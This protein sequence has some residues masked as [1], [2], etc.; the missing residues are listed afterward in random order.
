MSQDKANKTRVSFKDLQNQ[1]EDL[2]NKRDVLNKKTKEYINSLQEIDKDINNSLKIAKDNYKK[3]RNYWNGKV[4]KLKEKKIEY[5][6]ILDKFLEE[7]K[8][9]RKLNRANKNPK[10]F[11]SIKEIDRKIDNLERLIETEK[12]EISEENALVDQIRELA[13][14]KRETLEEKHNEGLF[15]IERKIEIVKINLNK[16]YEQL[17]KWSTKSQENHTK[18]LELYQKVDDLKKT[19]KKSEE[20]LIENKKA[21]DRYHEQFL[22]LMNQRKKLNKGR[23]NKTPYSRPDN[24]QH[25][26]KFINY[27]T[28]NYELLQKL[29]QEKLAVALEKQK[30]GKKL[31]L[32]EARLILE[33]PK[34]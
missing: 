10:P 12:L 4:K 9:I 8:K 22:L 11:I 3:K 19:K 14:K 28:K 15:K 31:N 7:K 25:K 30:T 26:T 23:R 20:E 17:N 18:M 24:R 5:K 33:Q 2:K 32:F 13:E 6:G 21:A 27:K 1:I 29:K 34:G 16:I